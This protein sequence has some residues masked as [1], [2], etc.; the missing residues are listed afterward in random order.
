M[1]YCSTLLDVHVHLTVHKCFSNFKLKATSGS[2]FHTSRHKK[3]IFQ[4]IS[5]LPPQK[6]LEFPEGWGNSQSPKNLKKYIEFNWNF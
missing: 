6:E 3:C 2:Q 4:K 5:M 1:F